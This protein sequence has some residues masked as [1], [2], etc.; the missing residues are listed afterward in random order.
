MFRTRARPS[1]ASRR[2]CAMLLVSYLAV[3]LAGCSS[4]RPTGCSS[5][6]WK[7][8]DA[9]ADLEL[10]LDTSE[11][12]AKRFL[13]VKF[14][15]TGHLVGLEERGSAFAYRKRCTRITPDQSKELIARW[16]A[17]IGRGKLKDLAAPAGG[18]IAVVRRED[19]STR[20]RS[21]RSDE[22]ATISGGDDSV[23]TE[24]LKI[25]WDEFTFLHPSSRSGRIPF[26]FENLTRG[27]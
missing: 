3:V 27:N 20:S 7:Q 12:E 18:F 10:L 23:V 8:L 16:S 11:G 21:W 1:S 19:G 26:I 14:Y 13:S 6:L 2:C 15:A 4:L 9:R 24:T 5:S 22:I 25:V 17:S